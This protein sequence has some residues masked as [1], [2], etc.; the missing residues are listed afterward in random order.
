MSR[1]ITVL[2]VTLVVVMGMSPALSA[3][4]TVIVD[5]DFEDGEANGFSEGGAAC[6]L[7]DGAGSVVADTSGNLVYR[8]HEPNSVF[9]SETQ[10]SD[11]KL[12]FGYEAKS[13][14]NP[15]G[16]GLA[17]VFFRV[18]PSTGAGYVLDGNYLYAVSAACE[19]TLV[20]RGPDIPWV[21]PGHHTVKIEVKGDKIKVFRDGMLVIKAYDSTF[22][23]GL[24]GIGDS[25]GNLILVDNVLLK[26]H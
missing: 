17:A 6:F 16:T 15:P 8:L 25:A 2:L 13:G 22:D 9:I 20:Q 4:T 5:E 7:G 18:D 23:S 14:A 24:V 21:D 26:R 1:K 10:V 3:E 19:F 12:T 11:F